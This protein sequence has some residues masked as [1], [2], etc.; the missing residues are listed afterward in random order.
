M[1][2]WLVPPGID[3]NFKV[4]EQSSGA[5]IKKLPKIMSRNWISS[6]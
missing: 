1:K 4:T 6:G 5:L 2:E 3:P